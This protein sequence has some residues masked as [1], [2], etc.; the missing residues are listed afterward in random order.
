MLNSKRRAR[1]DFRQGGM[2]RFLHELLI[3]VGLEVKPD[4]GGPAEVALEAERGIGSDGPLAF[5]DFID[6]PGRDANI[7]CQAVFGKAQRGEEIFAQDFAG[8]DGSE[9]FH[10]SGS[11][12]LDNFDLV[13][14]VLLPAEADAPWV[15]DSNGVLAFA[16]S[17]ENF[18]TVT[19]WDGEVFEFGDGLNLSQFPQRDALD[20]GR[21]GAGF[22]FVEEALGLL[23]GEGT[24]HRVRSF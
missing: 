20:A 10:G 9:C 3:V 8:M 22:P 18:Q 1:L 21:K 15:V 11:V 16:V 4:F 2:Q 14:T 13:R 7:L 17:F 12:V 5:D 6:A 23:A 19:G 24:D